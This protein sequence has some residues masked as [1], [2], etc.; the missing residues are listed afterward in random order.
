VPVKVGVATAWSTVWPGS[1]ASHVLAA[2]EDLSLWGFGYAANGQTAFA[3]RNEFALDL[4]LPALSAKQTIVF[5]SP[6]AI[7]PGGSAPLTATA[8]S[9]L[10]VSFIVTG[11]A[12]L[13]NGVLTLT[14]SGP[15][16]VLAWQPGDAYWQ[17]SDLAVQTFNPPAPIVVTLP[18]SALS[19]KGAILNGSVNPDGFATSASFQYGLTT[20]YDQ[21]APLNVSPASGRLPQSFH[22]P[23][24][25]LA[26]GT[27]YHYRITATNANGTSNGSDGMFTTIST[28]ASLSTLSL[29]TGPLSPA[30]A[31][32]VLAYTSSLGEK[33]EEDVTFRATASNPN[34]S[35]QWRVNDGDYL[36]LTSGTDSLAFDLDL[37]DN[38]IEVLVTAQD[39]VTTETY[40][41]TATVLDTTPPQ[42]SGSFS[43]L[44]L[45][46]GANATAALPDYTGQ[47]V[48]TDNVGVTAIT[49]SPAPGPVPAGKVRVTVT[50]HDAAGNTGDTSFDVTVLDGT[51]P[52]LTV[53]VSQVAE[54]TSPAGAAVNYPAATAVDAVTASPTIVYSKPGGSVFP[55]GTTLVNVTAT[56]AAGNAAMGSFSV[57]VRDTTAPIITASPADR[58]LALGPQGTTP[59]PSLVAELMATDAV[60]VVS[61]TQSPLA[62]TRCRITPR[63]PRRATTSALAAGFRKSRRPAR[64][65]PWVT[66]RSCCACSMRRATPA[67][68]PCR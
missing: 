34:A 26:P 36:P 40:T 20:A 66:S 12:V 45:T 18:V 60:G 63:R 41:I 6:G 11:P 47:A 50:A 23:L 30:F 33:A 49:Q 7:A 10:P 42:I 68:S 22:A 19:P 32:G 25:G 67:L 52:M 58:T 21:T 3:G 28:D 4:V 39:G 16:T 51:P 17:S 8:A 5:P 37:G 53:P 9:G 27:T 2:A 15:V 13:S 24:T 64:R 44:T 35:I 65:Y 46:T 54:A 31:S 29:S 59:I 43:P 56:D 38:T 14:G 62:G 1:S 55:L 61:V 57:L 48:A